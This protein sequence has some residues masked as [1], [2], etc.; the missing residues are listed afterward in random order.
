MW[1]TEALFSL[2]TQSFF[3]LFFVLRDRFKGFVGIHFVTL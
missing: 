3:L 2:L 1:F